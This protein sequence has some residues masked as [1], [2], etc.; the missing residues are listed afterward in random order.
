MAGCP[1]YFEYKPE[2]GQPGSVRHTAIPYCR[3]KHSPARLPEVLFMRGGRKVLG[4]G[5][6]LQKCQVPPGERLDLES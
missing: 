4:C 1:Y 5:G 6:D 2:K 3:H